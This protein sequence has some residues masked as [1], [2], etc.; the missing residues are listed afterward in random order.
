MNSILHR[1][2]HVFKTSWT[3]ETEIDNELLY[4]LDECP[5]VTENNG[6]RD[7]RLLGGTCSTRSKRQEWFKA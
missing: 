6:T 2:R 3:R 4:Y 7:R 1:K 5:T